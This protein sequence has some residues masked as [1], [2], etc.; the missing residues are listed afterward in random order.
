M[1]EMG[2]NGEKRGMGRKERKQEKWE[3]KGREAKEWNRK[4]EK[5]GA[6]GREVDG[7][8]QRLSILNCY[9]YVIVISVGRQSYSS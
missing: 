5:L 6:M 7:L 1:G 2:R 9:L 4:E 8:I 3:R